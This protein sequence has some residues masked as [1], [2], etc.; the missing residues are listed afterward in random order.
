MKLAYTIFGAVINL[1][2]LIIEF[3]LNNTTEVIYY[4]IYEIKE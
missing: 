1:E 3:W 4:N 2:K